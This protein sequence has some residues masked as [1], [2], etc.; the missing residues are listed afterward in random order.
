MKYLITTCTI[1]VAVALILD[2]Q[3]SAAPV[4]Y[5]LHRLMMAESSGN[6]NARSPAGACGLY[7][8]MQ[9]TWEDM[10]DEPWSRCTDPKLNEEVAVRYLRWLSTTL[11]NWTQ[12]QP[13]DV[14][15]F[16]A[17][18]GGIGRYRRCGYEL[19]LMPAETRAFVRKVVSGLQTD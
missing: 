11:E 8:I 6:P 13:D 1:A 17:W 15:I 3:P 14:D 16:A 19:D 5:A 10:T 4:E 18:N 9:P 2:V 7:Q 12:R